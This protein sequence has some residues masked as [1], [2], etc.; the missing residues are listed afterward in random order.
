LFRSKGKQE[1][2]E[3]ERERVKDSKARN[4]WEK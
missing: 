2:V 1:E 4:R 3:E